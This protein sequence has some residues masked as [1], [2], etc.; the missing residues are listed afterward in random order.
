MGIN[1]GH[2]LPVFAELVWDKENARVKPVILLLGFGV[3]IVVD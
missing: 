3:N 1:R 2:K